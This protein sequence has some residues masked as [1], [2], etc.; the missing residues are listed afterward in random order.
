MNEARSERESAVDLLTKV[1]LPR[2]D[3]TNDLVKSPLFESLTDL[4]QCIVNETERYKG[5]SLR[6]VGEQLRRSLHRRSL[7]EKP[8]TAHKHLFDAVLEVCY[9]RLCSEEGKSLGEEGR[10]AFRLRL[11]K[12]V[13]QLNRMPMPSGS[14]HAPLGTAPKFDDRTMWQKVTFISNDPETL[15]YRDNVLEHI[16]HNLL[17]GILV[18]VFVE[19]HVILDNEKN[20][21]LFWALVGRRIHRKLQQSL[22]TIIDR[23]SLIS[24]L[25]KGEHRVLTV[26]V[27]KEDIKWFDPPRAI[28][29]GNGGSHVYPII[30]DGPLR[31]PGTDVEAKL[32]EAER[33]ERASAT[34]LCR[35]A[36]ADFDTTGSALVG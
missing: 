24:F 11:E 17:D 8:L 25:E 29:V 27:N 18:R 26:S 7:G 12:S 28:L 21:K 31:A 14:I 10:R 19:M 1:D 4:S 5:R 3:E 15:L 30:E 9:R 23:D 33:V 22:D 34:M 16:T 13:E 20:A 6:G 2:R 32:Q 36:L 35:V